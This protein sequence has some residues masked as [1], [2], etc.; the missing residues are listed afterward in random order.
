MF[1]L[2]RGGI[3]C[4]R[5]GLFVG[6]VALLRRSKHAPSATTWTVRPEDELN[7]E[8]SACYGFPIDVAAKRGGLASVAKALN[9]SDMVR[10][11]IGALLLRLP[12]PPNVEKSTRPRVEWSLAV[13]LHLS[14]LLKGD[15][16]PE[17]HPRTEEPPNPG[18]FAPRS[19]GVGGPPAALGPPTELQ[20]PTEL[21]PPSERVEPPEEKWPPKGA[22]RTIEGFGA[23]VPNK[24]RRA[25]T[26]GRDLLGRLLL[27][28][29]ESLKPTELNRGEP[30]QASAEWKS[31]FD[32]PKTL[33]ELQ[34]GPTGNQLGYDL[35]H[36]V[37]QNPANILKVYFEKFGRAKIDDPSNTIW[38]PSNCS[39]HPG[40]IVDYGATLQ[41]V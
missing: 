8:L 28:L 23:G 29:L 41:S 19:M 37:E 3:S 32:P 21:E 33:E 13:E 11:T 24:R 22:K 9:E 39:P 27:E 10:A 14:D 40:R 26:G 38:I 31:S 16:D 18:W 34:T 25:R 1:Q 36:I 20:P 4:D 12:D 15:W 35:H 7:S 17:K 6:D 30:D 5:N 2:R